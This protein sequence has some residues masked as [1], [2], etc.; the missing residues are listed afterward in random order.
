[1]GEGEGE[2]EGLGVPGVRPTHH[3]SPEHAGRRARDFAPGMIARE[4]VVAGGGGGGCVA[5]NP[6]GSP[7]GP[8]HD[9]CDERMHS[10]TGAAAVGLAIS[11]VCGHPVCAHGPRIARGGLKRESSW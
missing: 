8:G 7:L 3:D 10:G 4:T 9:A 6:E 1:M 11:V 5:S 2:G